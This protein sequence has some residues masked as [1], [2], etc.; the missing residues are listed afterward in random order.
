MLDDELITH[1]PRVYRGTITSWTELRSK[2][3]ILDA[4]ASPKEKTV[5]ADTTADH[6]DPFRRPPFYLEFL[7]LPAARHPTV[8]GLARDLEAEKQPLQFLPSVL[9]FHNVSVGGQAVYTP[10][11]NFRLCLSFENVFYH[12][13]CLA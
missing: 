6:D 11:I 4:S 5:P 1:R 7:R 9:H 2:C 12:T 13:A 10:E 3:R 8:E